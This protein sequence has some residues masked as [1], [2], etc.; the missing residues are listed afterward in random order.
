MFILGKTNEGVVTPCRLEKDVYT[1]LEYVCLKI[2]FGGTG[3]WLR[4]DSAIR[5]HAIAAIITTM[6]T[7]KMISA[8]PIPLSGERPKNLSIKCKES[9][10][11]A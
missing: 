2:R 6:S 11:I 8:E 7:I 5:R 10:L 9:P 1:G 3:H 4:L